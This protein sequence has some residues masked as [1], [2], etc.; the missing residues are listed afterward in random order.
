[1]N[2]ISRLRPWHI[3]LL[4]G[5]LVAFIGV[6]KYGIGVF[7]SWIY[8]Y[9]LSVNWSD[10]SASPILV[11][12]ADYLRSNFVA[13]WLAGA[14]GFTTVTSHFVFHVL[15]AIL[16]IILPFLMPSVRQSA[17]RARMMFIAMAGG[18]VLPVLLLWANGYDAVT[19]I[20]LGFAALCR[21]KY[22]AVSGWFIATLNHPSV[23]VVALL[24]WA[25]V[26]LWLHRSS[27]RAGVGVIALA[28]GGVVLGGLI[29]SVLMQ[30]WGGSTSRLDWFREQSF[31]DFAS[32]FF[33]SMPLL[34]FSSLG[35][36]WFVLL[37][38][39]VFRLGVVRVLIAEAVV[40]S[41]VL[42]WITLD[43]TRTVVLSLFAAILVVVP[44]VADHQL[45]WDWRGMG[46]VAALVPVPVIWSGALL[47]GGWESFFNLDTALLPPDGYA[48]L[49]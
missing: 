11:P 17:P 41:L 15:L 21:N 31:S 8:M 49:E 29:N 30:A 48:V 37:R 9:D 36:L 44:V 14:L 27:I 16:A 22:V 39:Q 26:T 24:A 32:G 23:G 25:V 33:L 28:T 19:V 7:P 40:L 20:G 3:S 13:A 2:L 34:F 38:P 6:V 45:T 4:L 42:P 43:T 35:V 1:M 5:G 10:P 12:P 46:V 47:Y 18:A